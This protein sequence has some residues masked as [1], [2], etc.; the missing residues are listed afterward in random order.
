MLG[1]GH[2][3]EGDEMYR[4]DGT[5]D[6]GVD[7]GAWDANPCAGYTHFF[8]LQTLLSPIFCFFAKKIYSQKVFLKNVGMTETQSNAKR[9]Q[10]Q[11]K[12]NN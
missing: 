9:R 6:A 11:N 1:K 12:Y 8:F 5:Y 3:E 10:K 4:D 2:S 7:G